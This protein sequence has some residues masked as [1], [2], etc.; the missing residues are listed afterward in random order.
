MKKKAFRKQ[1]VDKRKK[2]L[3]KKKQTKVQ[4]KKDETLT[5]YEFNDP[6]KNF[7]SEERK[8]A[9]NT[10]VLKSNKKIPILYSDIRALLKKHDPFS[11]LAILTVEAV[12]V[13]FGDDGLSGKTS[14]LEQFHIELLQSITLQLSAEEI[15]FLPPTPDIVGKVA[16]KIM[17]LGVCAMFSRF[18]TETLQASEEEKALAG[19]QFQL[20]T[21]TQSVRNWGY[22]SQMKSITEEL[23]SKLNDDINKNHGFKSEDIIFVFESIMSIVTERINRWMSVFKILRKSKNKN[24]LVRDYCLIMGHDD[25]YISEM[26]EDLKIKELSKKDILSLI[27]AHHSLKLRDCFEFNID[28]FAEIIN[29]PTDVIK[30]IID[31]TCLCSG[32]LAKEK[33]EFFFLSNPIWEK[34]IIKNDNV[35]YCFLPQLFFAFSHDY[36]NSLL[37]GANKEKVK[38]ARAKY[39]EDKIEE[40]TLRKFP[41]AETISGFKWDHNGK[42]Y[43]TDLITFID[44]FMIIIE[45]KSHKVNKTALRGAE[46]TVKRQLEEMIVEA[47]VQSKRLKDKVE[48]LIENPDV[49]DDL[50]DKLPHSLDTIKSIIR[51]SVTLEDFATMQT[52]VDKFYKTKWLPSDYESCPTIT[53]ADFESIFEIL[54]HPIEVIN[55][56]ERR[57][58]I[59]G[60]IN[61]EGDELDLLG[62]YIEDRLSFSN[63]LLDKDTNIS[64]SGLSDKIDNYLQ[65][66][67]QGIIIDKPSIKRLPYFDELLT[68]IEMK[69]VS[70]WSLIGNI[71]CTLT[72]EEQ[73]TLYKMFT[74]VCKSVP[75]TY[76]NEGHIN[77]VIYTPNKLSKTAICMLVFSNKTKDKRDDYIDSNVT[78]TFKNEDIEQ[79]L[80]IGKNIDNTTPYS[81]IGI[82]NK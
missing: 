82:F 3:D 2:K 57:A 48:Y 60:K 62:M 51:V 30:R 72:N 42:Q 61:I 79:I 75:R 76:Q 17:D 24:E 65:S 45:A 44:S 80:I 70:G 8:N 14:K 63:E 16:D 78:E 27:G 68:T 77:S 38:K 6:F 18:N 36:F 67:E 5:Y 41:E 71:L 39:L 43:E 35:F 58:S 28:Y 37:K 55:Y 4:N 9:V 52:N 12:T 13:G 64:I 66:K 53:L 11:I 33:E 59:S 15:G 29:Y 1:K 7:T 47:N 10:M 50:R 49:K 69:R 81:F 31:C 22:Q 19:I 25:E 56:L 20:R 54:E 21:H 32:D 34:N 23:Y 74:D 46:K 40:I 26:E 73:K